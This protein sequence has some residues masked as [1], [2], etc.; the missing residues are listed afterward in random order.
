M[1]KQLL[2]PLEAPALIRPRSE[3]VRP[4]P[5]SLPKSNNT[6][7]ARSRNFFGNRFV[8]SVISQRAH[9][10]SIGVNMNP[11]KFCNFDC[12]YCEVY[13]RQLPRD[14]Q[15]NCE[16]MSAELGAMLALAQEGKIRELPGHQA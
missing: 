1:E 16:I 15:V 8:Y 13:R 5:L 7:A 10:L 11:D 3:L 6:I 12:V 4:T 2:T 9:G 14:A